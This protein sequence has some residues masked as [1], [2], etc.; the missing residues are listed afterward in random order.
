[1]TWTS[2]EP[3]KQATGARRWHEHA[4]H[5]HKGKD[6][7]RKT[8]HGHHQHGLS[9][10]HRKIFKKFAM[11]PDPSA[12]PL[13]EPAP[14]QYPVG[15]PAVQ[16]VMVPLSSP[17]QSIAS[18]ERVSSYSSTPAKPLQLGTEVAGD[19]PATVQYQQGQPG[20]VTATEDVKTGTQETAGVPQTV[21][22]GAQTVVGGAQ[23]EVAAGAQTEPAGSQ[24]EPVVVQAEP[25]TAQTELAQA[26]AAGAADETTDPNAGSSGAQSFAQ[27]A[28]A[29]KG[30]VLQM[31]NGGDGAMAE[32]EQVKPRVD[33]AGPQEEVKVV[34]LGDDDKTANQEDRPCGGCPMSAKCVNGQCQIRE[35]DA[36]TQGL[37]DKGSAS[38]PGTVSDIHNLESQELKTLL[39]EATSA[40]TVAGTST[41]SPAGYAGPTGTQDQE[42]T[43]EAPLEQPRQPAQQGMMAGQQADQLTTPRPSQQTQHEPPQMEPH[44]SSAQVKELRDFARMY[45]MYQFIRKMEERINDPDCAP[46]C[47]KVC[48][49]FCLAKCCRHHHDNAT[50]QASMAQTVASVQG[51][52]GQPSKLPQKQDVKMMDDVD[53]SKEKEEEDEMDEKAGRKHVFVNIVK[54]NVLDKPRRVLTK[55]SKRSIR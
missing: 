31:Y 24:T 16:Q 36:K 15:Q 48:K 41:E 53:E 2:A 49:A 5:H 23:T 33:E 7:V 29:G 25:A 12:V 54:N 4:G 8:K 44:F 28:D 40:D 47:R 34:N 55:K 35:V 18:P 6:T 32:S 14:L 21:V 9:K 27:A 11:I 52:G 46:I 19:Q 50:L 45:K 22:G 30:D 10:V 37:T 26:E 38:N 17:L 39:K 43:Q 51:T 13:E 1:M 20:T 3:G 42:Q